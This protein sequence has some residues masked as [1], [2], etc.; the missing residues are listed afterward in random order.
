MAFNNKTKFVE[1]LLGILS[2]LVALGVIWLPFIHFQNLFK[3][4]IVFVSACTVLFFIHHLTK[5]DKILKYSVLVAL[6]TVLLLFPEEINV[7]EYQIKSNE[8]ILLLLLFIVLF[9][10]T[11]FSIFLDRLLKILL[12]TDMEAGAFLYI[13]ISG[14]FLFV[15]FFQSSYFGIAFILSAYLLS[16]QTEKEP[17]LTNSFV[18]QFLSLGFGFW[19]MSFEDG[20]FL[21][22]GST[23]FTLLATVS[24]Y[25]F[26]SQLYTSVDSKKVY[27][28]SLVLSSCLFFIPL[29]GGFVNPLFGGQQHFVLVLFI[30]AILSF[31]ELRW[32]ER[33]STLLFSLLTLGS[34]L[35]FSID[36]QNNRD[37][38]RNV[39]FKKVSWQGINNFKK[40]ENQSLTGMSGIY[41]IV[42]VPEEFTFELGPKNARTKGV[43]KEVKGKLTILDDIANSAIDVEIPLNGLSTFDEYRDEVLME[44]DYFNLSKFSSISFASHT[45]KSTESGFNMIGDMT[46]LG[47]KKEMELE[48]KFE[49]IDEQTIFLYGIGNIDRTIF[50]MEPDASIGNVVDFSF[51][52]RLEK[53]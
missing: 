49:K 18:F 14:T 37:Q 34:I 2:T 51:K 47:V 4:P 36:H 35:Y 7:Q 28:V 20:L 21:L 8:T 12:K 50:G 6:I 29:V 16:F 43:F 48:V 46:M 10:Q 19:L 26:F 3:T 52:I 13:L 53:Q 27:W 11:N 15:S 22:E 31:T 24:F 32:N 23:L 9:F 45:F 1:S 30:L 39:E 44:E 41:K 40:L 42:E 17:F 33:E 38:S 25:S 5:W